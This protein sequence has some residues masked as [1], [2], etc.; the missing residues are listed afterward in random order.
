MSLQDQPKEYS[1]ETLTAFEAA[2]NDIHRLYARMSRTEEATKE[3]E[4]TFKPSP[5]GVSDR[6]C[7]RSSRVAAASV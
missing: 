3:L 1:P 5:S 2:Y 4:I 7:D 6:W